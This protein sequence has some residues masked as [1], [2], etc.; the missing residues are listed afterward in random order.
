[1]T[2]EAERV[3]EAN[4]VNALVKEGQ[5]ALLAGDSYTAR[6][7]FRQALDLAPENVAALLGMAGTV[8]PYREKRDFLQRA[9]ELDA[10]NADAR[11]S[12]NF[13]EQKIAAGEVLAPRGVVVREPLPGIQAVPAP[14]PEPA[15]A[16]DELETLTCYIHPDRETGLRCIQCQRPICGQCMVRAAVG[17]LCPECA[18]ARRPRNYQVAASHIVIAAVLG[19]F[20][21]AAM[22]F[23]VFTLVLPIPFLSFIIAFI[24]APVVGE[25]LVRILDRLTHAKRGREMQLATGISLG[26]ASAPLPLFLFILGGIIAGL[27]LTLFAALMIGTAVTRLR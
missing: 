12:L 21:G 27:V 24:L 4:Q 25:F 10:D 19:L 3:N 14:E 6:Q 23:L 26:L 5:A 16:V 7:H 17:Q 20:V 18:R 9:L 11:A 13:V 2:T 1:M 15:T 8:L 22:S